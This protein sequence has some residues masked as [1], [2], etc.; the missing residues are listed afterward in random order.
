MFIL[1][2]P[3]SESKNMTRANEVSGLAGTLNRGQTCSLT[4]FA[5]RDWQGSNPA[6]FMNA[7]LA[8]LL[9]AQKHGL[10]GI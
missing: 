10:A 7:P 3:V 9:A 6:R 2:S 4:S 5:V 1:V 8:T